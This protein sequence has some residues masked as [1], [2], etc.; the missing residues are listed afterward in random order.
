LPATVAVFPIEARTVEDLLA[1]GGRHEPKIDQ[2]E[3][4]FR[5]DLTE[6]DSNPWEHLR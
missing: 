4:E 6:D 2:I 5:R 3:L 1:V